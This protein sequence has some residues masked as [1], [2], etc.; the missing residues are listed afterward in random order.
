MHD[1]IIPSCK[2]EADLAGICAEIRATATGEYNLIAVSGPGK[3]AAE[4]RNA[5][6][7]RAVS[8]TVIMLDDDITAF[9]PGWNDDLIEPLGRLPD[10]GI[11]SARLM[12][13][14]GS[15]G[16]MNS[17]NFDMK[18]PLVFVKIVPTACIAFK[19][20]GEYFDERFIGS[21]FEDTDFCL[22]MKKRGYRVAITN[23]V[24]VVHLHEQKNQKPHWG[25][26]RKLFNEKWGQK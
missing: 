21:G 16:Y 3:S 9:P 1:I 5:G 12:K 7:D 22:A 24:K 20:V 4:N 25:Q 10:L 23:K 8:L 26:N 11:V 6:L 15:V 14:D 13:K 2:P 18:P 19:R 17:R